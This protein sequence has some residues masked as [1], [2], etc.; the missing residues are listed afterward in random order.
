MS[1]NASTIFPAI[2]LVRATGDVG[3]MLQVLVRPLG[4][5]LVPVAHP[6]VMDTRL[7]VCT[8]ELFRQ[9]HAHTCLIHAI[10]KIRKSVYT[11]MFIMLLPIG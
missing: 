5:I 10:L 6:R 11:S 4:A 7:S 3:A 9:T 1:R 8:L 2:E